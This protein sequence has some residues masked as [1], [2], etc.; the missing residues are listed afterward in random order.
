MATQGNGQARIQWG[1]RAFDVGRYLDDG[2]PKAYYLSDLGALYAAD[3]MAVLPYVKSGAVDTVFAD[4]P[5]NLG[6][7][8]GKNSHDLRPDGEY[9]EWCSKWLEECIRIL[10][11]GDSLFVYNLPK[12]RLTSAR[13]SL[14]V[15]RRRP[16]SLTGAAT[17]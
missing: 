8:Y 14:N 9:V 5:C 11:P 13:R 3:C 1:G 16:L 17:S 10:K 15:W 7:E 12:L 4:P 2:A 6:K